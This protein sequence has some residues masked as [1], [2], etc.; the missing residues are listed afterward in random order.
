[1]SHTIEGGPLILG[2]FCGPAGEQLAQ[3]TTLDGQIVIRCPVEQ[4]D[5][6]C[7]RWVL[8]RTPETVG[9]SFADYIEARVA[10]AR[11]FVILTSTDAEERLLA[12][13][14][15]I[16]EAIAKATPAEPA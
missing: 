5:D 4:M 10:L 1:M 15:T 6:L 12:F 13:N 7:R 2:W 11:L 3:V 16:A 9:P 14:A 8:A